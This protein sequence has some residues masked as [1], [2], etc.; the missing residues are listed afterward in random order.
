VRELQLIGD[1]ATANVQLDTV[2]VAVVVEC[3]ILVADQHAAAGQ[4]HSLKHISKTSK[5]TD[6][7]LSMRMHMD[8]FSKMDKKYRQGCRRGLG[9]VTL[10]NCVIF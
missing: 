4:P 7:K 8:N 1:V 3:E 9:H 10:I 6:S 5:A 2:V